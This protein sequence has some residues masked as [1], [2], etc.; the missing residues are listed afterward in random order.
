MG[1]ND[2]NVEDMTL[3][4]RGLEFKDKSALVRQLE[5]MVGDTDTEELVKFC[6]TKQGKDKFVCTVCDFLLD[7]TPLDAPEVHPSRRAPVPLVKPANYTQLL[8]FGEDDWATLRI[9]CRVYPMKYWNEFVMFCFVS[10][11][12]SV[13]VDLCGTSPGMLRCTPAIVWLHEWLPH[14]QWSSP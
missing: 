3:Y 7:K 14:C 11:I 5:D 13:L 2:K 12:L 10:V 4:L 8:D 1:H 9:W 6:K